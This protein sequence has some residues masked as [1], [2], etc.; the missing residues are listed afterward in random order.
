[1]RCAPAS[2]GL[3]AIARNVSR[4]FATR[5]VN[6]TR[7]R[8]RARASGIAAWKTRRRGLW[9][10]S[11]GEVGLLGVPAAPSQQLGKGGPRLFRRL[12]PR[13][14]SIERSQAPARAPAL[15]HLA[16]RL[17]ARAMGRGR[18]R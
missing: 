13:A 14:K 10:E 15:P 5:E 8:G 6:A 4:A 12:P 3:Q 9:G 2:S 17:A 16:S 18:T 11:G 1:M 7:I